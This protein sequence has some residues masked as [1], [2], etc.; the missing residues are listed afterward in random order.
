[1]ATVGVSYCIPQ[2]GFFGADRVEAFVNVNPGF[3][4]V[5]LSFSEL[6]MNAIFFLFSERQSAV[7]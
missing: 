6:Y 1:M 5:K 3:M 4:V 7:T 2:Q